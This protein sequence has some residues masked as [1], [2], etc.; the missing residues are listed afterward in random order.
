MIVE[1]ISR[2]APTDEPR[3]RCRNPEVRR[4][5][6]PGMIA[7]APPVDTPPWLA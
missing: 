3:C 2:I 4:E 6:E 5:R 1:M 7:I